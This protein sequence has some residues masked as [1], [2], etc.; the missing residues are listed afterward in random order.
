VI[1]RGASFCHVDNN[2]ALIHEIDIITEGYHI[3]HGDIPIFNRRDIK[4]INV[5]IVLGMENI[6]HSDILLISNMLDPR[7]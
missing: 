3:W 7:A 2:R 5:I 4:I 6:N 1:I